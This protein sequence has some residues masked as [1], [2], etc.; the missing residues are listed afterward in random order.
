MT[1]IVP[2]MSGPWIQ[3]KYLYVP[4]VENVTLD[5]RGSARDRRART[6]PASR[7]TRCRVSSRRRT[8]SGLGSVPYGMIGVAWFGLSGPVGQQVGLLPPLLQVLLR[9][10]DDVVHLARR[11][12][13]ERHRRPGLHLQHLRVEGDHRDPAA[14]AHRDGVRGGDLGLVQ[15]DRLRVGRRLQLERLRLHLVGRLRHGRPGGLDDDRRLHAGMQRA[16]E[17]VR[18]RLRERVRRRSPAAPSAPAG[19]WRR[20]RRASPPRSSSART[21]RTPAGC[22]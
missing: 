5:E 1:T 3:Q 19:P 20:S 15:R 22:R 4:G 6:R 9:P 7:R 11:L 10:E 17:V 13:H 21:A 14:D 2:P 18:P 16:E 8:C 12:V